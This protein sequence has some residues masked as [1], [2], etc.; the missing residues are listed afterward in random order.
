MPTARPPPLK[1]HVIR[2]NAIAMHSLSM[3]QKRSR[4]GGHESDGTSDEDSRALAKPHF[5]DDLLA[6]HVFLWSFKTNMLWLKSL[7]SRSPLCYPPNAQHVVG[8]HV[9]SRQRLC[10]IRGS[11]LC[12]ALAQRLLRFNAK[13]AVRHPLKHA[14]NILLRR[15]FFNRDNSSAT[16]VASLVGHEH[17]SLFGYADRV[18]FHPTA[19]ILATVGAELGGG[20]EG[21]KVKLWRMSSDNSVS[22]VGTCDSGGAHSYSFVRRIGSF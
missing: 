15:H 19:L 7:R 9:G 11:Q 20:V 12:S 10:L 5:L 2:R 13:Y 17:D 6:L 22:C 3:A 16:H 8:S 14:T 21:N 4:E 1:V 18:A